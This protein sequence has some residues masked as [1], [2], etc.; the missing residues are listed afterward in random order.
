[1]SAACHTSRFG[2]GRYRG[3]RRRVPCCLA[4]MF[5]RSVCDAAH[6]SSS[7]LLDEEVRQEVRRNPAVEP[8]EVLELQDVDAPFA[9]LTPGDERPGLAQLQRRLGWGHAGVL[10][11]L[12]EAGEEL[13]VAA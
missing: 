6:G 13:A 9:G 12:P 1:S 7:H 4:S 2:L 11:R 8:D 3:L 5:V 10:P